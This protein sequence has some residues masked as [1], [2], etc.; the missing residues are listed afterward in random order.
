MMNRF[1]EV[2]K[3]CE[4]LD[5]LKGAS[6]NQISEAEIQLNVSFSGEYREYLEAFGIA[7]ANGHEFTGICNSPRLNVVEVTCAARK[8]M[9]S[10]PRGY[11]VVE[12]TGIDGIIIWQD[13]SG[14]ILMTQPHRE[15]SVLS[16][17]LAE[18]FCNV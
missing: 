3:D 5:T 16:H 4:D 11:Y 14:T 15:A 18:Y 10:V 7:S 17:S 8:L 13:V 1:I 6:T 9:P 12:R 2:L